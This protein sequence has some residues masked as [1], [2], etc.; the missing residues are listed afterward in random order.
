MTN[1]GPEIIWG[2]GNIFRAVRT[3]ACAVVTRFI[4]HADL[5]AAWLAKA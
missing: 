5:D 2:F 3:N 4:S 1:Q